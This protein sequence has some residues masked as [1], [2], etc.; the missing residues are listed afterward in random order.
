M[1]CLARDP[2]AG[3][4]ARRKR[5]DAE[6]HLRAVAGFLRGLATDRLQQDFAA[7][8]TPEKSL[9]SRNH[10]DHPDHDTH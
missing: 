4:A 2:I 9:A 7:V 10:A 1:R 8:T 6:A 5:P 3:S